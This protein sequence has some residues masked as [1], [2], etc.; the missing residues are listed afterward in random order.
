LGGCVVSGCKANLA[1]EGLRSVRLKVCNE[2]QRA[3][4]LIFGGIVARFC[5]Q[6]VRIHPIREF[7]SDKRGCRKSL[8]Q[9]NLRYSIHS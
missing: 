1:A 5:Q 6:C 3:H 2:H 4:E 7:D 9:H 8:Q